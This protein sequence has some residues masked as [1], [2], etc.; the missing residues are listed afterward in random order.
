V[1]CVCF[2]IV[3]KC[4]I[5]TCWRF[6]F[7]DFSRTFK[8][9]IWHLFSST[10]KG[11]EFFIQNSSTFKDFSSTLWTLVFTLP[12][13]H[14]PMHKVVRWLRHW[15][16]DQDVVG[17]GITPCNS[18]YPVCHLLAFEKVVYSMCHERLAV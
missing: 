6:K 13:P 4:T 5:S 7:K 11:L 8:H 10:F 12:Y 1:K 14:K 15:T 17:Q 2:K 16:R 18:L 9:L 3:S